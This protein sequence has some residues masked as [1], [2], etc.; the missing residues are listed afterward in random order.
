MVSKPKSYHELVFFRHKKNASAGSAP[1]HPQEPKQRNLLP[2][3]SVLL[4]LTGF[5]CMIKLSSDENRLNTICS[6]D[7]ARLQ[8]Y[9]YNGSIRD[10][11]F[12]A[13]AKQLHGLC[14]KSLM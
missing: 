11:R 12:S 7:H 4:Q 13:F 8:D 10:R 9:V 1:S 5:N 14:P 3:L 2:Q 6:H